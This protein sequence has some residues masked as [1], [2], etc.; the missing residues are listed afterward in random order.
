MTDPLQCHGNGDFQRVDSLSH[1]ALPSWSFVPF[2]V[3]DL[4]SIICILRPF[5]AS[6]LESVCVCCLA[7]IHDFKCVTATSDM[8]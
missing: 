8:T 6:L 3:Y 4:A 2:V 7:A 1:S 5:Q